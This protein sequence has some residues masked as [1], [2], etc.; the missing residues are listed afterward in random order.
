[1]IVLTSEMVLEFMNEF[2][3][4]SFLR[5]WYTFVNL[6]EDFQLKRSNLKDKLKTLQY[7][8]RDLPRSFQPGVFLLVQKELIRKIV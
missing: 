7:P 3:F 4:Q 1:M 2:Y 6:C 8:Y 5:Q